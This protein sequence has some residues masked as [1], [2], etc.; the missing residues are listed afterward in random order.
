VLDCYVNP[1]VVSESL[2]TAFR[3]HGE[4]TKMAAS[5]AHP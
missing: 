3:A 1:E 5:G 4:G 2:A